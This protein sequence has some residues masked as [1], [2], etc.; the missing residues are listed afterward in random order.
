MSR[1]TN[2]RIC[3]R[4]FCHHICLR[5]DLARDLNCP[6]CTRHTGGQVVSQSVSQ[7]ASQRSASLPTCQSARQAKSRSARQAH[8]WSTRRG[9]RAASSTAWA[10]SMVPIEVSLYWPT[11]GTARQYV[12]LM[13]ATCQENGLLRRALWRASRGR[14]DWI[15]NATHG[16]WCI[17]YPLLV[18]L[19]VP[20]TASHNQH[21]PAAQFAVQRHQGMCA[22]D[23]LQQRTLY[24][25]PRPARDSLHR[26]P[27]DARP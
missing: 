26:V 4:H 20:G 1:I 3:I 16:A 25:C 15:T 27:C 9:T 12:P 22:L 11:V 19:S 23:P 2:A 24:V 13:Q 10:V 14:M 7:L 8:G 21:A 5:A 6:A 18:T 17:D